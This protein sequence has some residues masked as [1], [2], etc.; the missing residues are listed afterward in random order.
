MIERFYNLHNFPDE[1]EVEGN[2]WL[3]EISYE[4][5]AEYHPGMTFPPQQRVAFAAEL[6]D[7]GTTKLSPQTALQSLAETQTM[8]R[9]TI[10]PTVSRLPVVL[11][12]PI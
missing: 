9:L 1:V 11:K 12:T 8:T 2:S 6:V 5:I 4:Q 7:Q 3:L 10:P